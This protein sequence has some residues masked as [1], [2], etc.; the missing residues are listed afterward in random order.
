[1]NKKVLS[2]FILSLFLFGPVSTLIAQEESTYAM[3]ESFY[4]TPDNTKLKALGESMA[5]HNKKYHSEAPYNAVVYNVVSG[6]N[7]G[8]LVWRMGPLNYSHLDNRPSGDG[9]D[10]DWRDNVM[11]NIKKISTGEYWKQ[12]DKVSNMSM[13]NAE[14]PP[15]QILHVRFFEV[16]KGQGHQIN[17]LFKQIS[18]T[19]KDMEGDNPWGLYDNEFRQGYVI[20]RHLASVSF[21]KNWAEYDEKNKFKEHFLKVNGDDSWNAFDKGMAE[22]FSNSWDEIEEYNATLSGH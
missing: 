19:I 2:I 3:W 14:T 21:M 8:K 9:H 13:V 4:I 16:A 17:H 6:P 5:N 15:F 18:N 11:P 22:T 20:G 7:T 10:E 1:M 12:D